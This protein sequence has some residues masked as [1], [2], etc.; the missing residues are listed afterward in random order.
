MKLLLL[1]SAIFLICACERRDNTNNIGFTQNME[2]FVPVYA[3]MNNLAPVAMGEPRST[4]NPGKIYVYRNYIFQN[5]QNEGI[6][7]IDNSNPSQPVKKAFLSIPYNT[8]MAMRSNHIYANSVTDLIVIDMNDPMQ[9]TVV[10][11]LKQ[12]FPLLASSGGP[13]CARQRTSLC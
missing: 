13:D 2:A 11:T 10:K 4:T 3:D 5:E 7:I 9:P 8:E 12:A 6:H 1:L